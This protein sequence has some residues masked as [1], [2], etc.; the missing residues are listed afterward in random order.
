[1]NYK[2]ISI[3]V[4]IVLVVLFVVQ[5]TDVVEIRFLFWKASMSR[6][7]VIIFVL[8]AGIVSGWLL[9]GWGRRDR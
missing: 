5:N 7:L 8:I 9:R 4:L 1:M 3:L 6:A 2:L